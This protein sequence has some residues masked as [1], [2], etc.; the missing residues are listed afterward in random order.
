MGEQ[1]KAVVQPAPGATPGPDLERELL[2]FLRER[3]AHYK[4]PRSIDFSDDLPRTP[5]GKLQKRKLRERYA[6]T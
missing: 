2:A 4:V 1:V 5:T 3:I 6:T